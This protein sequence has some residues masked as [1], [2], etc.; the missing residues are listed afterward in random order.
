M[1]VSESEVKIAAPKEVV[2]SALTAP[3]HVKRWQ[4]GSDL[5]TDWSIG[6]PIRFT[7][8][9][10]GKV[11][12]QWGEVLL[13]DAPHE[14]RYSLFVPQPGLEDRPENRFTM[15][16]LLAEDGSGTTVTIIQEDPRPVPPGGDAE[17]DADGE[18]PVLLA[19]KNMAESLAA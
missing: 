17:D 1:R 18:N 16:Y 7:T 9:W 8:E 10:D 11:F 19:L 6:S 14:L 4:Y 15:I 13:V 3:E 12:E 2:W 5:E